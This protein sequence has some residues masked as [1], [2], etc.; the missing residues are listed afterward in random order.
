MRWTPW[1]P[2]VALTLTQGNA[3][4]SGVTIEGL[5]LT[6]GHGISRFEVRPG[7][8]NSIG[9]GKPPLHNMCP[10]VVVR[11]GK[12]HLA[13]GGAGGRRIVNGVFEVL[14]QY[15]T[16]A[17][18]ENAIA[19]P[20]LNTFGGLELEM[21]RN[22]PKAEADYLKSIGFNFVIGPA[23]RI[24]AVSIDWQTGEIQQASR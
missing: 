22:W 19:A 15:A 1:W 13:I 23:A 5:G 7:H 12:P 14:L 11:E 20:R 4:G 8:P 21:E 3:F 18:L 16:G 2:E 6:F 9:P 10:T 17:Q 24:T